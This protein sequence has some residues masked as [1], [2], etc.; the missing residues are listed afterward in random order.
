M[1]V[2]REVGQRDLSFGALDADGA[3]EQAHDRLLVGEDMLDTSPDRRFGRIAADVM[4]WTAP[5]PR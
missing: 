1:H 3:D 4:G 5:A 2:E